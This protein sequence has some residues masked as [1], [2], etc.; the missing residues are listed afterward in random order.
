[1][2]D[3]AADCIPVPTT[4]FQELNGLF[5]ALEKEEYT[6][7]VVKGIQFFREK[8]LESVPWI[9]GYEIREKKHAYDRSFLRILLEMG[10]VVRRECESGRLYVE[11]AEVEALYLN[12]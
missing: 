10:L 12:N 4:I 3:H 6:T 2:V 5:R 7:D 8:Y 9:S 11:M 1:M